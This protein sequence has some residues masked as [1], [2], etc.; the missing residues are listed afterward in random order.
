MAPNIPDGL[1]QSHLSINPKAISDTIE[2][3][4]TAKSVKYDTQLIWCFG[5][6][7]VQVRSQEGSIDSK[8]LFFPI[9]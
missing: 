9:S 7:E 4:T 8:G 5:D 3:F 6:D 2:H 1:Q